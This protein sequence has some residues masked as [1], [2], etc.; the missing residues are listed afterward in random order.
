MVSIEKFH[1]SRTPSA[2]ENLVKCKV[3]IVEVPSNCDC[4]FKFD[5]PVPLGQVFQEKEVSL[6]H[7]LLTGDLDCVCQSKTSSPSPDQLGHGS[8][9]LTALP[10]WTVDPRAR[11]ITNDAYDL[12]QFNHLP[13]LCHVR[14]RLLFSV[15]NYACDSTDGVQ[16]EFGKLMLKLDN[17]SD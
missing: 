9:V 10:M 15:F 16:H 5:L 2:R 12:F 6:K 3:Q 17:V 4:G 11:K 8:C 14:A 13:V 7:V 1:L